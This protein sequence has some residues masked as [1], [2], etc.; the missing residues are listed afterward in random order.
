[1]VAAPTPPDERI[2][3][4]SLPARAALLACVLTSL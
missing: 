3:V 4:A 2:E 1:L